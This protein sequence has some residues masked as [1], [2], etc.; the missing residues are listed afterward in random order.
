M[1]G[2]S[3]WFANKIIQIVGDSTAEV[4]INTGRSQPGVFF[5]AY[6]TSQ[7]DVDDYDAFKKADDKFAAE[8]IAHVIEEYYYEQRIP[9]TDIP[10]MGVWVPAGPGRGP[11]SRDGRF[12]ES[13]FSASGFESQ[14][15]SDFTGWWEK[16]YE[17][18]KPVKTS[19]GEVIKFE[20][21]TVIYD[22]TKKNSNVV[23]I[24]KYELQKPRKN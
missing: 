3:T 10:I 24:T 15:L 17:D 21:S 8:S 22:V 16:P 12:P 18:K 20:F 9:L 2:T 5:D 1:K 23:S 19:A 6:Q 7:L 4:K 11:L 13:H 14:V